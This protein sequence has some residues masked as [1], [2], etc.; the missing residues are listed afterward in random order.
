MHN[1]ETLTILD[2]QD[3][4]RKQEKKEKKYNHGPHQI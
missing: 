4:G 2:T 3:T 1:P